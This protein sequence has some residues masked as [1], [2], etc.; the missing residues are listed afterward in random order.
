MDLT[1]KDAARVLGL[2]PAR[3]HQFIRQSR[4]VARKMG[5]DWLIDAAS[6]DAFARQERRPGNH[7]GRP[8]RGHASI[9]KK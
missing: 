7:S 3:V 6:V 2:S 1:V 4:L 8:R 9:N 5:R